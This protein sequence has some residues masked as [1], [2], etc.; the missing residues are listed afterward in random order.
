MWGIFMVNRLNEN[1]TY[2]PH[3]AGR[4][5]RRVGRN[6]NAAVLRVVRPVF[7]FVVKTSLSPL[8]HQI[9][10][11]LLTHSFPDLFGLHGRPLLPR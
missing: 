10:E 6:R 3:T 11:A 9:V 8:L 4:V 2:I 5:D 7:I 1:H